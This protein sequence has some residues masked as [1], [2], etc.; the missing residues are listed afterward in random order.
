MICWV[1]GLSP[2]QIGALRATPALAGDLV[3]VTL[4]EGFALRFAEALKRMPEDQRRQFEAATR[5][6]RS[7]PGVREAGERLEALRPF[8]EPL[9]LEKSWHMLHYLFTGHAWDPASA[10]GDLLATG[11]ELGEDVGYGPP[12]LHGPAA[13]RDFSQFLETQDLARL[14]ARV[15][16]VEMRR[17]GVYAIPGG[18][19]SDAEFEG[20]LRNEVGHFFPRLRDYVRGMSY[21]GNGLL[22]WLS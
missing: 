6:A 7:A 9:S 17:L 2:A 8:E 21:K 11:E 22:T 5:S 1:R 14:Q 15:N 10:P 16:I 12:R 19:G 3:M 20:Q 18:R 4:N 13:T